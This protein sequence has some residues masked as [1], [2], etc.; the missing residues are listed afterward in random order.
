LQVDEVMRSYNVA[1]MLDEYLPGSRAWM[2]ARVNAW[3]EKAVLDSASAGQDQPQDTAGGDAAAPV[4]SSRMFLL[5]A[6]AGMVSMGWYLKKACIDYAFLTSLPPDSNSPQAIC[7]ACSYHLLRLHVSK[8]LTSMTP[9]QGKSVFSAVIEGQL[10]VEQHR[11]RK[12]V[13]V[14]SGQ[15]ERRATI[16]DACMHVLS[17]PLCNVSR[18]HLL[19]M[20]AYSK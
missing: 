3:L 11:N 4:S 2:Y 16:A 15:A 10:V 7:C 8:Y 9:S 13:L 19:P 12:L 18:H 14:S 6:D 17:V 5:L 1:A 20:H